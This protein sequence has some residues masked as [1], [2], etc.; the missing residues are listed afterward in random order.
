M[1]AL[2]AAH[3]LLPATPL[4]ALGPEWL[5]P[6]YIINSFVSWVGPWAVLGVAL[7]VFA[8]TGL[9]VGFFLPGDSLLFTL[10][11]FVGAGTVG[12]PIWVRRSSTGRTR[13]CSRRSTWSARGPSSR[14]TGARR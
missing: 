13:A 10:G 2:T 9:L 8:E 12:V 11:M 7:V 3:S 1:T 5:D 14:S 6:A 4:P